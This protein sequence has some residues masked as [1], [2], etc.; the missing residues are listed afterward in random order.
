MRF[1]IPVEPYP[2]ESLAGLI[3]RATARNFR[4]NPLQALRVVDVVTGAPQSLCSRSPAL[5]ASIAKLIGSSDAD[6]IARMFHPPIKGR[7][8]WIDFFGEPLRA[9]YRDAEKRRGASRAL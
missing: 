4:R 8:G 1:V 2:D 3:V 6:V 7:R 5:A 9:F